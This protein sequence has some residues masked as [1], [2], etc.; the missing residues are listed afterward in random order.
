MALELSRDVQLQFLRP[1]QLEARGREFPVVYVPFGPIEWHGPHLPLGTDALKAHA[2]LCLTAAAYGG[3]V[4]PPFFLHDG[5]D[6]PPV[7]ATITNLFQRLK[8]T[9]FRVLIGISGHN[10]TGM[11]D[12]IRSALE[13]VV[14]DGTARGFAGWEVTLSAGEDLNTDHAAKWETSD[15]MFAYPDRVDMAMLGTGTLNLDM[16]APWG[17]GG[18]DPR[19]HASSAVGQRCMELAADTIGRRAQ[20]LLSSLPEEHRAFGKPA[21]AVGQWWMV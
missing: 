19:E 2:V 7:T 12:M 11:I 4:Y 1:A 5:W 10:V 9:G 13:P 21:I 18:L 6:L 20:E 16:K 17:I 3:V 8:G 15:M 14:A